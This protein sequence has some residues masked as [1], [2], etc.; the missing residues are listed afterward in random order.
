MKYIV[1][2]LI[3]IMIAMYF[4]PCIT[5]RS[6]ESGINTPDTERLHSFIIGCRFGSRLGIIPIPK[7]SRSDFGGI[8]FSTKE[9]M[10][11]LQNIGFTNAEA[12]KIVSDINATLDCSDVLV[13]ASNY[14][15]IANEIRVKL[16]KSKPDIV[17]AFR[18]GFI[19]GYANEVSAVALSAIM[20][21]SIQ[22]A[23]IPMVMVS[24]KQ[25]WVSYNE[26]LDGSLLP[27]DLYN[28]LKIVSPSINTVRELRDF[29]DKC[30][31][32]WDTAVQLLKKTDSI[33]FDDRNNLQWIQHRHPMGF[34]F[35]CR[36]HRQ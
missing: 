34:V 19:I 13:G 14:V 4:W 2:I 9:I 23:N 11:S 15:G 35:L 28:K 17:F 7:A 10:T 30:Y 36:S 27:R 26:I 24:V 6:L 25:A 31:D 1:V 20:K 8:Q 18:M 12:K 22:D 5:S 3:L 33:T 32:A 29:R 16:E 21:P